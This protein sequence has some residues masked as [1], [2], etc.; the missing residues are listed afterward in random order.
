M[1]PDSSPGKTAPKT[2]GVKPL[3]QAFNAYWEPIK[4]QLPPGEWQRLV[5]TNLPSGQ[6]IVGSNN[7]T[8]LERE[9]VIQ[10]R[11]GIVLEG[12]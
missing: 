12:K 4:V 5:D 7:A 9:Y 6:D 1:V 10:P 3:Y 8:P 2:P 11:S